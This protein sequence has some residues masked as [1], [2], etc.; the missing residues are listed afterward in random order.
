MGVDFSSFSSFFFHSICA[1][2]HELLEDPLSLFVVLYIALM[3]FLN[4]RK[5]IN[6]YKFSVI[7]LDIIITSGWFEEGT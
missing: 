2:V 6:K 5:Q 7:E 4:K 3:L 1:D